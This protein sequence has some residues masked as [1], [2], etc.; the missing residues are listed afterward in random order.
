MRKRMPEKT[1]FDIMLEDFD[2]AV[3]RIEKS[4]DRIIES[5]LEDRTVIQR[6]SVEINELQTINKQT[7]RNYGT[8]LATLS[9]LIA[10][11][12]MLITLFK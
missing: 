11:G 6:H 8:I 10:F 4:I 2:K 12:A 5:Q 7:R 1:V 3:L 9:S